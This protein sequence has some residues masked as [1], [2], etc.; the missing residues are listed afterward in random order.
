MMKKNILLKISAVLL[1]IVMWLFVV[2]KEQSVITIEIPIGFRNLPEGLEITDANTH[3][4]SVS[5]KGPERFIKNISPSDIHIYVDMSN[6][7]A[8]KQSYMI[9]NKAVRAPAFLKIAGIN[10]SSLNVMLDKPS[11]KKGGI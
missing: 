9:E 8:G 5:L 7:K 2:S 10:P 1:A 3:K 11:A 6:A 4:T